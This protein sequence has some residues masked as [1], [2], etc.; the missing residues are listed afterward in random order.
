MLA[1]RAAATTSPFPPLLA[2]SSAST[3]S[4]APL[5]KPLPSALRSGACSLGRALTL[6]PTHSLS[7]NLSRAAAASTAILGDTASSPPPRPPA[8]SR[9]PSGPLPLLF[10]PVRFPSSACSSGYL[11]ITSNYYAPRSQLTHLTENCILLMLMR[12]LITNM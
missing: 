2:A 9:L 5:S 12:G 11:E 7:S 3:L 8:G 1:L 6:P 10:S 4:P